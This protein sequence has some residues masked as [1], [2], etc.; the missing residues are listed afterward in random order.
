LGRRLVGVAMVVR[1]G[2][3]GCIMVMAVHVGHRRQR[4]RR[5]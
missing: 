5:N 4:L 1:H 2:V 3:V